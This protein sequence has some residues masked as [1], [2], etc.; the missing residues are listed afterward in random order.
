MNVAFTSGV[1]LEQPHAPGALT[2]RDGMRASR[3]YR[4]GNWSHDR[5]RPPAGPR[6]PETADTAATAD[7]AGIQ[8]APG[9][10]DPPGRRRGAA[11]PVPARHRPL[12]PVPDGPQPR[13]YR[14]PGRG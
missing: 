8:G 12:L 10:V 4:R 13:P 3:G 6:P 2:L 5:L 9:P 11:A 14:Q 7:T 1:L